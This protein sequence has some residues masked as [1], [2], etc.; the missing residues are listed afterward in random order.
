MELNI[1][2]RTL[3]GTVIG[4][5]VVF[6]I[7]LLSPTIIYKPRGIYLPLTPSSKPS[8]AANVIIYPPDNAPSLVKTLGFISI[9]MHADQLDL[10]TQQQILHYAQDLAAK[11]GGAGIIPQRFFLGNSGVLS[12]AL[13]Q[14]KVIRPL[15]G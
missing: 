3:I 13:F 10:D 14:G 9:E 8:L 12:T 11:N 15:N 2:K 6:I 7:F 1:Q 4:L 5:I